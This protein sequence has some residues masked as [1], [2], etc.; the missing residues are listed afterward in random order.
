VGRLFIPIYNL[1]WF[2]GVNTTLCRVLDRILAD[3]H[4]TRRAPSTL[5]WLAPTI[6]LAA[7]VGLAMVLAAPLTWAALLL[8]AAS[9]ATWLIYMFRCD[10]ARRAVVQLGTR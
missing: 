2:F 8:S 6:H 5:S 7:G 9:D 3:A 4:D 1:Y 10:V